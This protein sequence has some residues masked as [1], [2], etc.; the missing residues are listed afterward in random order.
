MK[1]KLN[2]SQNELE[3]LADV[4][5]KAKAKKIKVGKMEDFIQLYIDDKIAF[6]KQ[7]IKK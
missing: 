1:L 7:F 6:L 5:K 3:F 2:I 4:Y